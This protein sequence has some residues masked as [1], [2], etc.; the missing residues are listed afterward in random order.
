MDGRRG[1]RAPL[2]PLIGGSMID[3]WG[4]RAM[5][6]LDIAVAVVVL[7]MC[8]R[9]VPVAARQPADAACLSVQVA[10]PRLGLALITWV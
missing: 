5:F 8:L 4:W 10:P 1:R 9:L 3:R 6:W 2:G 7:A